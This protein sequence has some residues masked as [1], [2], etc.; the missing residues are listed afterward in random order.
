V[1][2]TQHLRA[3]GTRACARHCAAG[4]CHQISA[5]LKGQ[6]GRRRE[7]IADHRWQATHGMAALLRSSR[8]S[9]W[10]RDSWHGWQIGTTCLGWG[11][12]PLPGRVR[13]ATE[14]HAATFLMGWAGALC[15]LWGG[16]CSPQRAYL[17]H[18]HKTH[19]IP[20][21]HKTGGAGTPQRMPYSCTLLLPL[22]PFRAALSVA[23]T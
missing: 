22:P 9:G 8:H 10:P 18:H 4:G 14:Q 23:A 3:C 6:G 15:S 13:L 2:H 1:P 16:A 17:P 7:N 20:P 11:T 12:S 5:P 19:A 21:H